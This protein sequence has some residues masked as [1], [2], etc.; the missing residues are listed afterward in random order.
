[1]RKMA[2]IC[3]RGPHGTAAGREGLDALL[4]ASALTDSVA[5]FLIGDGVLQLVKAQQPQAILQRHYAPTFKLLILYDIDDIYVCADSLAERGLT[6][7]D[8]LLPVQCLSRLEIR[9]QWTTVMTHLCF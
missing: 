3:R 6:P 4:A 1:M 8:L 9:A 5:L 2:F 7:T